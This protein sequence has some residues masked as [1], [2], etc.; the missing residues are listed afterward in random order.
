MGG[1][2]HDGCLDM[3]QRSLESSMHIFGGEHG[4][5]DVLK[6]DTGTLQSRTGRSKIALR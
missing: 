2:L 5:Y 6:G 1:Y 4:G 3:L